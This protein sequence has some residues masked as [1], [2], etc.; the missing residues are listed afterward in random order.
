M[1]NCPVCDLIYHYT[2]RKDLARTLYSAFGEYDGTMEDALKS[3]SPLHLAKSGRMPDIPYVIYHCERDK[4]V[5]LEQH[6]VRF[7][8]E[9]RKTRDITLK[10]VPLRGHCNLS[11]RAALEY[12]ETTLRFFGE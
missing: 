4:S 12:L 5:N 6:S 2:E 10:T 11:P 9:M 3:C 1:T 8:E 7:V